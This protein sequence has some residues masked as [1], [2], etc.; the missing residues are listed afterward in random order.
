MPKVKVKCIR[1]GKERE[2]FPSQARPFCSKACYVAYQHETA[3]RVCPMCGKSFT[4][5]MGATVFCSI[6]CAH[7]HT[8]DLITSGQMDDKMQTMWQGRTRVYAETP[9]E[10]YWT[11]KSWTLRA[12]DGEIVTVSNLKDYIT[13]SGHFDGYSAVSVYS[14]LRRRGYAVGWTLISRSDGN[15][16]VHRHEPQKNILCPVCF[17]PMPPWRTTCSQSCALERKKALTRAKTVP[18]ERICPV[19]GKSFFSTGVRK[20]CSD[21]CYNHRYTL[22]KSKK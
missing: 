16:G 12:P 15:L 18:T 14:N 19:C 5:P 2:V 13:S 21:D 8:S 17:H 1:C 20:Y 11:A 22:K 10:D 9:P 4:A 3:N 7:K 6:D